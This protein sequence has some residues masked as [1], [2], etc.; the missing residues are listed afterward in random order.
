MSPVGSAGPVTL[1]AM[2]RVVHA[3]GRQLTCSF[4]KSEVGKVLENTHLQHPLDG[5]GLLGDVVA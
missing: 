2:D 1:M 4:A 3:V 5:H